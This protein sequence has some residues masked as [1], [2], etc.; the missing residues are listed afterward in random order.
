MKQCCISF[1]LAG[2]FLSSM[3]SFANE[4]YTSTDNNIEIIE[5]E[6]KNHYRFCEKNTRQ[7]GSLCLR[8][9]TTS[10]KSQTCTIYVRGSVYLIHESFT[11]HAKMRSISGSGMSCSKVKCTNLAISCRGSIEPNP[12]LIWERLRLID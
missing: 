12:L 11:S 5:V 4:K 10:S 6:G 2:V 7:Q 8:I 9:S 1:F 3:E